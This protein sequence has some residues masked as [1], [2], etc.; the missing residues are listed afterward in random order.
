MHRIIALL[1][2]V[3]GVIFNSNA[4]Q[5]KI[6]IGPEIISPGFSGLSTVP[7]KGFGATL[8]FEMPI[9]SKS[10]LMLRVGYIDFPPLELNLFNIAKLGLEFTVIPVELGPKIYFSKLIYFQANAEV[11]FIGGK[12]GLTSS[13]SKV[14]ATTE[15]F[16]A[17][18]G[19]I[20]LGIEP[21]I[22]ERINLDISFRYALNQVTVDYIST[23]IGLNY[24]L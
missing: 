7:S 23:R 16:R 10:S 20:G 11:F 14:E 21:E 17:Y 22:A 8:H 5:I 3:V 1:L 13:D 24:Q 18:G 12:V 15:W 9:T 6:G 4:Q 2:V 19:A